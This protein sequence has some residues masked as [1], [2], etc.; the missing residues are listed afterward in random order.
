LLPSFNEKRALLGEKVRSSIWSLSFLMLA[1]EKA[2]K[3]QPAMAL[4]SKHF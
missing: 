2:V 4:G 3:A 1:K